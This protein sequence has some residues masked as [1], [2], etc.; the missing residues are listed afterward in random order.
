MAK[1]IAVRV[2]GKRDKMDML[3][4]K[5]QSTRPKDKNCTYEF[6]RSTKSIL[7]RVKYVLKTGVESI[8]VALGGGFA[9]GRVVE[10]YGLEGSGKSAL[11]QRC[12]VQGQRR[13]IYERVK[14]TDGIVLERVSDK[15]E[16]FCVYI[17]NE[18]SLDDGD[19]VIIDGTE[20]DALIGRCDTVDQMFKII[21]T[22]IDTLLESTKDSP[23][24]AFILIVVDTIAGTSSKEEMAAKWE[25]T[26]YNRQPKQ[27]RQGFRRMVRKINRANVCLVCTNQVSERFN[28]PKK[29]A[30]GSQLP[31]DDDFSSFGGRALKF[32]ASQ[33]LF[34]FKL[35]ANYKLNAESAFASG[36]SGCF[37][38][39]KNR[40]APPMRS[41]RFVVL[42]D[43]KH[44]GFNNLFGRLETMVALKFVEYKGKDYKFRFSAAGIT[45]TTFTKRGGD[46]DDEGS[47]RGNPGIKSKEEWPAFVQ[48][49]K[50]DVDAL[51]AA[52]IRSMFSDVSTPQ[53]A[54][55]DAD[56]V[57]DDEDIEDDDKKSAT[58][59]GAAIEAAAAVSE[60]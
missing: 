55:A 18:Q 53:D 46:D 4:A 32:Y 8:D 42:F 37:V 17:D 30:Y 5:L 57:L 50:A 23:N 11:V 12:A 60:D 34:M 20:I 43:A 22:S 25:D 1:S 6:T 14:S 49:H 15:C 31:S 56:E 41:G 51:W 3:L 39:T 40:L 28:G 16:F 21:D 9:F 54:D 24:P 38:I 48:A 27:L 26:D 59:A 10:A 45:T 36:F 35:N 19:K 44:G 29:K 58:L 2:K 13:E 7:S 47:G 33:R 52:T